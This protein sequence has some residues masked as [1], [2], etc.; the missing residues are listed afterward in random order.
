MKVD[1]KDIRTI[2][3]DKHEKMVKI[4]DQRKLPHELAIVDLKTVDDAIKAIKDMYVRGAPLI[5]VT[6]AYAVYLAALNAPNGQIDTE[7]LQHEARRI[8]SA[9]PTAVNLAWGVEMV[10]SEILTLSDPAK[11]N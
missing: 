6:G 9:R 3:L 1:G 4:I 5:G 10:L 8:K 2:W 11:E 7:Y